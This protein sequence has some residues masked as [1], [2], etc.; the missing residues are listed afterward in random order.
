MQL[1][2]PTCIH[3]SRTILVKKSNNLLHCITLLVR[4]YVG[5]VPNAGDVKYIFHTKSGPGPL[6]QPPSESLLDP[7]TGNPVAPG[8]KHK[9]MRI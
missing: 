9:R 7:E 1:A 4:T 5:R 8:P 6:Q 2:H 3:N